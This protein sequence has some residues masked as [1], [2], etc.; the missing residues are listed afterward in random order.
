MIIATDLWEVVLPAWFQDDNQLKVHEW[1]ERVRQCVPGIKILH[2]YE[3]G[4]VNGEDSNLI[5]I[6]SGRTQILEILRLTREQY[7]VNAMAYLFSS[8]CYYEE[9]DDD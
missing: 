7:E 2:M 6:A 3:A 9:E 8:C 1:S 4:N 5:R